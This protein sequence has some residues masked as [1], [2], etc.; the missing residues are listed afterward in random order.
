MGTLIPDPLVVPPVAPGGLCPQCW[1]PGKAFGDGLTPSII[2]ATFEGIEKG[3]SWTVGMP[4]PRNETFELPQLP[5]FSCIWRLVDGGLQLGI[6]FL[7]DRSD[8]ILFDG[9]GGQQFFYAQPP[10]CQTFMFNEGT[11]NYESGSCLIVIPETL[12]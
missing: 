1:G 7:P 3:P 4:E 11:T 2:V 5:G 8:V 10:K 9:T 12:P 6:Q